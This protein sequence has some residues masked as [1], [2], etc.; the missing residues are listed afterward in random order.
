VADLLDLALRLWPQV[1]D[2]GTVQDPNDL[3]RL[4]DTQG[5]PGA[6][7]FERGLRHTFACFLPS[8]TAEAVLPTGERTA[9][10]LTARFIAHLAVTRTLLGAGLAVDERVANAVAES[11]A[12]TWVA[13]GGSYRTPLALALSLW[14]VALDPLSDS[15]R[16]LP[17]DWSADVYNDVATWDPEQRLFSHYDIREY[18]ID[19]AAYVSYNRSRHA[20]VSRWT[21][22]EPLLRLQRDDRARLALAQL[23]AADDTGDRAPAAAMLERNR[24]A[25]LLRAWSSASA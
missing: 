10:D 23:S 7:G 15:D 12:L 18:A 11:H 5:Q 9:D 17:I 24:I 2:Q 19:W 1:R 8:E 20:G 4:L 21:I 16:P 13:A 25:G 14:L 3:D 22:I 6:P